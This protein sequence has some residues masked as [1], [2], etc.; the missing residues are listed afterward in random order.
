M[1]LLLVATSQLIA[2]EDTTIGTTHGSSEQHLEEA[3]AGYPGTQQQRQ[4]SPTAQL[5]KTPTMVKMTREPGSLPE[6]GLVRLSV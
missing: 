5:P 1:G 2:V 4:A 6:R 3:A